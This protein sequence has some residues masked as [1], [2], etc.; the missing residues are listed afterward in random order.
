MALALAE[1][2]SNVVLFDIAE[3]VKDTL[4]EV[5]DRGVDGLALIGDVTKRADVERA[6]RE[7]IN[8]FGKIDILVN[9]AGIYPMK[10]FLEMTEEEWDKVL[11]VNLK[12]TF[13]FSRSVAPYMVKRKYGRIINISSNAAVVGFPGLAH[14]CASKTGIVGLT[15]A[16]ALELAPHGI[17]VNA[18]APGP[19]ETGNVSS[20]ASQLP[21]AQAFLNALPVGRLG[22]PRDVANVVIFLASPESSFITGQLIV[23]DGGYTVH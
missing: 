4:L 8:T 6:A 19:I 18:I 2:G 21:N 22:K 23:V 5:K 11:N 14:Y 3:K 17:T 10:P 7:V 9:N 20:G 13:L 16:V 1:K 15:R 12:G